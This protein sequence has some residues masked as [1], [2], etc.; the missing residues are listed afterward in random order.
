[1]DLL[2][3]RARPD[4]VPAMAVVEVAGRGGDA[5]VAEAGLRRW[6]DRD[7]SALFLAETGGA[8]VAWASAQWLGAD[9]DVAMDPGYYLAGCTVDP[10]WRRRSLGRLLTGARLAWIGAQCAQE[11]EPPMA[12]YFAN[13]RNTASIA[14]HREF[15]FAEAAR[16]ERIHG[17]TF[18]GDGDVPGTGA[19]FRAPLEDAATTRG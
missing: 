12:W 1:M 11:G 14:M 7:R 5:G 9:G 3:R 17:V 10:A 16:A 15:G 13:V 19:L 4:D 6:L 2:V 8:V 18:S